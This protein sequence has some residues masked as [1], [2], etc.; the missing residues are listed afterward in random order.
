MTSWTHFPSHI[1][2]HWQSVLG[3]IGSSLFFFLG[4][5]MF[6]SNFRFVKKASKTEG[7]VVAEKAERGYRGGIDYHP[8]IRFTTEDGKRMT[9]ISNF[10]MSAGM[11]KPGTKVS[12]LYDPEKPHKAKWDDFISLWF[13]PFFFIFGPAAAMAFIIWQWILD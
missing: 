5:Y 4:I 1:D 3:L 13:F 10:G 2:F 7:E 12:V 6:I 8:V 11:P 9:F